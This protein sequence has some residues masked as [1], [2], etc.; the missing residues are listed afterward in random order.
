MVDEQSLVVTQHGDPGE[1]GLVL[2]T[3]GNYQVAPIIFPL[4]DFG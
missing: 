4:V 2:G 1:Q 3:V